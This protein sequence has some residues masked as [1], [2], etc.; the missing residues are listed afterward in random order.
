MTVTVTVD[1]LCISHKI[2]AW[3]FLDKLFNVGFLQIWVQILVIL[4]NKLYDLGEFF[5]G[6]ALVRIGQA[7]LW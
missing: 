4:L 7:M 3:S 6:S 1:L 5:K 2:F